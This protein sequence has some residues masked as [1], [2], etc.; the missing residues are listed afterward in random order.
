MTVYPYTL[1]LFHSEQPKLY[2]VLA[3]LSV[4]GTVGLK[5]TFSASTFQVICTLPLFL[6]LPFSI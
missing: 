5:A 3:V 2:G 4:V 1:A 6:L